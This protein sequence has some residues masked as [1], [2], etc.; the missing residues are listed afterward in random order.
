MAEV[1]GGAGTETAYPSRTSTALAVLPAIAAQSIEPFVAN[2]LLAEGTD[3]QSFLAGLV[4]QAFAVPIDSVL[5]YFEGVFAGGERLYF[6]AN[7]KLFDDAY[8]LIVD[9]GPFILA[10]S[11]MP[12]VKKDIAGS[13]AAV[14]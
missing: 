11:L 6:P 1:F 13:M 9:A 14:L 7:R 3:S 8:Q 4:S 2:A 5:A 12:I 10:T